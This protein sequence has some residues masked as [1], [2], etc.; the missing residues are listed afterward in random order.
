M[1]SYLP[2]IKDRIVRSTRTV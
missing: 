2:I 1:L